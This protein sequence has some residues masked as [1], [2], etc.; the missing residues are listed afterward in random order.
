MSLM[1]QESLLAKT[2]TA[3]DDTVYGER[4]PYEVDDPVGPQ[5]VYGESKL[6]GERR[7]L[8]YERALVVRTS[9]LV[10]PWRAQ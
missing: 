5:S 9:W 3:S 8:E 1:A 7:A 4:R 6:D 10:R 2:V